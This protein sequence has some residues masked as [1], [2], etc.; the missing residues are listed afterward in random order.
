MRAWN[1]QGEGSSAVTLTPRRPQFGEPFSPLASQS[2]IR[3]LAPDPFD[4]AKKI[5]ALPGFFNSFADTPSKPPSQRA[6]D[7]GKGRMKEPLDAVSF[8]ASGGPGSSPLS[9]PTVPPRDED[10]PM[11]DVEPFS[12][13]REVAAPALSAPNGSPEDDNMAVDDDEGPDDENVMAEIEP[14][15]WRDEVSH[16][17]L[18]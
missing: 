11:E 5:P 7:K 1:P 8:F 17:S 4:K 9:S 6:R 16:S 18:L 3:R 2:R 15:N 12:L 10:H 13:A 14:P